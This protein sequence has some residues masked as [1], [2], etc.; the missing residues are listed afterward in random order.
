M[1]TNTHAIHLL[2]QSQTF[3]QEV[4]VHVFID[5]HVSKVAGGVHLDCAEAS[6]DICTLD[7]WFYLST[8]LVGHFQ[9]LFC[10]HSIM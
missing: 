5:F 4:L 8:V 2:D 3:P 6:L 7:N 10:C 9:G 1:V